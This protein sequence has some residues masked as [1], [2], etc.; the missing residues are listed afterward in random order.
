MTQGIIKRICTPVP[1]WLLVC[2]C[3]TLLTGQELGIML[4]E[5][6]L[7]YISSVWPRNARV[8]VV[9]VPVDAMAPS[10]VKVQDLDL[11]TLCKTKVL[12]R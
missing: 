9:G 4:L 8:H 3:G 11:E 2:L 1:V 10:P 12:C 7:P 6:Q 5:Q